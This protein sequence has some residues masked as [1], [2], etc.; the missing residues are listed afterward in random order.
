[1]VDLSAQVAA[2]LKAKVAQATTTTARGVVVSV[3]SDGTV[4]FTVAGSTTPRKGIYLGPGTPV[5]GE[6][7]TYIDEGRGF[8]LVLGA[9]GPR[10]LVLSPVHRLTV[11][12]TSVSNAGVTTA[13]QFIDA[14][15]D[16]RAAINAAAVPTAWT[17]LSLTG[18]WS[19]F[20]GGYANA[21]YRKRGD[22]V[23]LRG[24]VAGGTIG[25]AGVGTAIFA[26]PSGFR[27]PF[28]QGF[29]TIATNTLGRININPD[30]STYCEIGTNT[31][32][33]LDGLSFSITA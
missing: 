22:E 17:N 14:T 32:V 18:G 10:D 21:S 12:L 2:A 26:L 1:M 23:Q 28:A 6:V 25:G 33:F 15:G 4:T 30:G 8:V 9:T 7:I 3:S 20:G 16:L 13:G 29:A 5:V 31:F 11:G 27:P 24:L 19:N